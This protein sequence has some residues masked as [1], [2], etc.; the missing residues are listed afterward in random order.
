MTG[1]CGAEPAGYAA[2][3]PLPRV[4]TRSLL[5]VAGVLGALVVLIVGKTLLDAGVFRTLSPVTPPD[6]TVIEGFPGG[7]ED[8]IFRAGGREAFVSVQDF[9][10]P[11]RPGGIMLLD[12]EQRTFREVTPGEWRLPGK[13]Q[14]HGIDLWRGEGVERL[15]VVN[16]PGGSALPERVGQSGH[17]AIHTVEIFDVAEDGSLTHARTLR[18]E[19]FVSPNDVAAVGPSSFYLSN[20]HGHAGGWLRAIEDYA[21]LYAGTVVFADESGDA[22]VVHEGT[23]YANGIKASLDGRTLYLAETTEGTITSFAR[24]PRTNELTRAAVHD[25][26]TGVDN[27]DVA[28][29]GSLLV[30]AHPKLLRFL[31]H[32]SDPVKARAPSEIIQLTPQEG[33]GFAQTT[34]YLSEG[35]PLS[36]SSVGATNGSVVVVGAVFDRRL[37]VFG[38]P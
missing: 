4:V 12:V 24:D 17:D 2:R 9:L 38:L 20:D 32:A 14:P 27:I 3:M 25:T 34:L 37:L 29:D 28:P 35:D 13:L 18:H 7:T 10:D 16:H 21:P 30:G 22:R 19:L 15:F 31:S 11:S 23:R 33:G 5:L 8:V 6:V 1:G 26:G 36:A